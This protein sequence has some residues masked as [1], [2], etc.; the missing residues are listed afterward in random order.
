VLV[1]E[2]RMMREMFG[3]KVEEEAGGWGEMH[4]EEFYGFLWSPN[5]MWVISLGSYNLGMLQ[6]LEE[7]KCMQD[8]DGGGGNKYKMNILQ[9]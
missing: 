5:I 3:S 8:F 6:G 2:N 4:N 1:F 9:D 7:E